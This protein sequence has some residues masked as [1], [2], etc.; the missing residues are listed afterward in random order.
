MLGISKSDH[1]TKDN[2]LNSWGSNENLCICLNKMKNAF[3]SHVLNSF[4][5]AIYI[6]FKA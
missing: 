2:N 1:T 4:K 6:M 5:F 3:Y